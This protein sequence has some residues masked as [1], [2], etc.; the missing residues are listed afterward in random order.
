MK[1]TIRTELVIETEEVTITRVGL[2]SAPLQC[3]RCGCEVGT[4]LFGGGKAN[5]SRQLSTVVEVNEQVTDS[6]T[7]LD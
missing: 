7:T 1:R 3:P 2:R 5:A 6:S 4:E